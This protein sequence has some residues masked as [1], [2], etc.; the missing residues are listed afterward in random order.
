V[1][2]LAAFAAEPLREAPLRNAIWC[3]LIG[4]VAGSYLSAWR[5]VPITLREARVNSRGRLAIERPLAKY[6][7]E[8]PGSATLLMY[9]AAHAGALQMAGIPRRN[10]ISESEH[11]DWEWALLDPARHAEYV[12]A[13]QGDPVWVAIQP[14]STHFAEL[15]SISALGQS[16]CTIYKRKDSGNASLR[17]HGFRRPAH[18]P[19]TPLSVTL[20]YN[21][22][23][24]MVYIFHELAAWLANRNDP[25]LA[26]IRKDTAGGARLR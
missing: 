13:C 22:R 10:V 17:Q 24:R 7:E 3:V 25:S 19:S 1:P 2:L 4:V 23:K 15:V 26:M 6:L 14:Q 11:P 20:C 12:V 5:D 8:I 18:P 9:T 21:P 16:R